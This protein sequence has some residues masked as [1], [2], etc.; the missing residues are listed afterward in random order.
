M[1]LRKLLSLIPGREKLKPPVPTIQM[2][3]KKGEGQKLFQGNLVEVLGSGDKAGTTAVRFAHSGHQADVPTKS[4]SD[5][6]E[7]HTTK[8]KNSDEG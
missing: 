6:A 1:I 7:A 3:T 4:L 5:I 8:S 2:A